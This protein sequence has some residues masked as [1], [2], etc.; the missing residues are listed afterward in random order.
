MFLLNFN[1]DFSQRFN[2]NIFMNTRYKNEFNST[3]TLIVDVKGPTSNNNVY[4]VNLT[5]DGK[6]SVKLPHTLNVII[7]HMENNIQLYYI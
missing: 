7:Y 3:Q 6:F 2:D 4:N 5:K 1:G